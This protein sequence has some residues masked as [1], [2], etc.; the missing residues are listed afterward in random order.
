EEFA[1]MSSVNSTELIYYRD[2]YLDKLEAIIVEVGRDEN[3]DFIIFDK[4]IFHPQG[5]GQPDDKGHFKLKNKQFVVKKLWAP[6][7]F[8]EVPYL[9][10]H[11]YEKEEPFNIEEQ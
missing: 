4:T 10:K 5:G 7:N 2:T 3:G 6:R 9:V 11:Y 8:N 1:N